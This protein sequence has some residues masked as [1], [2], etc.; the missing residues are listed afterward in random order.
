[1]KE[2]NPILASIQNAYE[3]IS[4]AL[5]MLDQAENA[6]LKIHS[7]VSNRVNTA[8]LTLLEA[9]KDFSISVDLNTAVRDFY[10][11]EYPTDDLGPSLIPD[12]TFKDVVSCINKGQDLYDT[13]GQ[14]I[15]T[16]IRERIFSKIAELLD[17][18]Y[19]SVYHK[20]LYPKETPALSISGP[21]KS[22]P[23]K[24]LA[25]QIQS[26]TMSVSSGQVSSPG[27]ENQPERE[28]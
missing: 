1:M 3:S 13:V 18:D 19:L 6:G 16:V 26:A 9:L 27:K 7:S 23:K 2:N 17:V 14:N 11:A 25:E 8:K 10:L 22:V 4:H 24:S 21:A 5:E 12:V 28:S 20:W 15:D